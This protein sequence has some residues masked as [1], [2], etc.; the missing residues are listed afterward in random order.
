MNLEILTII[1]FF[2]RVLTSKR[3]FVWSKNYNT[4][5]MLHL[6]L[7]PTGYI[8]CNIKGTPHVYAS[9]DQFRRIK[10]F[11]ETMHHE[12]TLVATSGMHDKNPRLVWKITETDCKLSADWLTKRLNDCLSDKLCYL[13]ILSPLDLDPGSAGNS[14]NFIMLHI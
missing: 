3:H 10:D 6:V 11:T 12:A 8:G 2:H 5:W 9:L 14:S 7:I 4:V 13:F 1:S